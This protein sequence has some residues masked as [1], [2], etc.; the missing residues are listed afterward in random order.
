MTNKLVAPPMVVLLLLP[1]SSNPATL[2]I[3]NEIV[4]NLEMKQCS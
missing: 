4:L 1:G 3:L 2:N